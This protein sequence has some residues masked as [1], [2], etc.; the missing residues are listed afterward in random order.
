MSVTSPE[1]TKS[2]YL[3]KSA[4]FLRPEPIFSDAFKASTYSSAQPISK[5]SAERQLPSEFFPIGEFP[6]QFLPRDANVQDDLLIFDADQRHVKLLSSPSSNFSPRSP[7][8]TQLPLRAVQI[9]PILSSAAGVPALLVDPPLSP[10][11]PR[12][13]SPDSF[14]LSG[15]SVWIWFWR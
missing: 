9:G 2:Q 15:R 12:P 8:P 4:A 7:S 1:K 3:S 10:R 6:S 11:Q 14:I 5:F 13:T